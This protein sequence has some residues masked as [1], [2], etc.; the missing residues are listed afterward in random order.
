M[1]RFIIHYARVF[2]ARFITR[3]ELLTGLAHLG[4]CPDYELGMATTRQGA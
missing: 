2:L 1:C 4:H 3:T